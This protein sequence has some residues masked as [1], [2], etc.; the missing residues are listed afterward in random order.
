MRS[1]DSDIY[2]NTGAR[3]GSAVSTDSS[4]DGDHSSEAEP[5]STYAVESSGPLTG[6]STGSKFEAVTEDPSSDHDDSADG[7][8][9]SSGLSVSSMGST[10]ELVSNNDVFV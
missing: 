3:T 2:S 8:Q 4:T 5:S 10:Q 1:G 9:G 7:R 6:T